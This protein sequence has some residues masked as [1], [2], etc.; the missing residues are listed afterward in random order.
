MSGSLVP[1]SPTAIDLAHEGNGAAVQSWGPPAAPP[2]ASSGGVNVGR[3]IAAVRRYKWLIAVI[4]LLGTIG[5]VAAT[6]II[7]PSYAVDTTVVVSESPDPKG[8]IQAGV[9]LKEA[10]WRE[11]LQSFAILDPV[12]RQTGRYLTPKT[13]GDS[14]IFRG[15]EPTSDLQPGNY[16]LRVNP[17]TKRYDLVVVRNRQEATVETGSVGDSIGRTVGFAWAPDAQLI[18]SRSGDVKFEVRTPREAATELK[19]NLSI[20]IPAESKFIKIRLTGKR[21]QEVAA[22]MNSVLRQFI[23]EAATLKRKNLTD[24]RI[25]LQEQYEQSEA[26]LR[27]VEGDLERLKVI[28]I[29]K[30]S[31][32]VAFVGGQQVSSSPALL[33]FTNQRVEQNRVANDRKAVED[34]LA[35]SSGSRLTAE[36]VM[37]I[38]GVTESSPNLKNAIEDLTKS[39]AELRRLREKWTDDAPLVKAKLE[40]IERMETQTLPS[41]TRG[42]LDQLRRRETELDRRIAGA[43]KEMQAIP[44]RTIEE[45]ALTRERDLAAQLYGE[46]KSRYEFAKL[47]EA[48]A[49]P[50]VSVLDSAVAPL[51]PSSNTAPMILLLGIGGSLGL[52]IVLALLLD[53]FDKRFRYPEQATHELG[54]DILGTIPTIRRSR[55]G[56]TRIED[57]AQLVEAFRGLRLNVRNAANGNGPVTLAISSPGPG[58]GKSLIS[59]NLA[60]AFA[61][62]G[63][64]TLLVDGDIRRG[65]LHSTFSVPQ[66]PGLVDHLTG[67]VVVEDVIRET[68]HANLF[69]IPCGT[70]RH[71]GP[72]LLA[73]DATVKMVRALRTRFDAVILD[74]APLGAGIDP[75]ALG[76]AAGTMLIVLRTGQTDRK[77]AQAKLTTLDRLPVRLIGAVLNDIQA[78]GM[79]KYYSYLDGYGTLDED[80]E[81]RLVQ[82]GGGGGSSLPAK[83]G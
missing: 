83:R 59:S 82:A 60:L 68:S 79:Y 8:P 64:R 18:S 80:E 21:S 37:S 1:S 4:M 27:R 67:E 42:S 36:A 31:D 70:R 9:M 74:T 30:P 50:D 32:Q 54:L 78:E 72:E 34:L 71:R 39:Q 2:P 11:L 3:Y 73:A 52:G 55:N 7:K 58:D 77:L 66:R 49:I 75:Y 20:Y 46:L 76:A 47:A 43:S 56:S 6:R 38:P 22:T 5:A 81:P 28:N 53:L 35:K 62:A 25:A 13:E 41:I 65:Q 69:V 17:T 19:N 16:I 40:E 12:A 45:A 61:E 44:Q 48:S 10:A 23:S 57:E 51:K 33:E 14:L 63:Y 15:F 26:T 29:T 24:E